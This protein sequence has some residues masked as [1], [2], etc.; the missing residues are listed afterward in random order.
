MVDLCSAFFSIP[1]AEESRHLFAFTYRG[2]QYSYK[3]TPQGFCH[4][5]H[6]FNQALKRDLEGLMLNSTLI[7]YVDDLLVCAPTLEDCHR[8]S[9]KLL[10]TL[11]EG[12]HKA[13]KTKLQYCQPQV[14]YLGRVISQGTVSI[15]PAQLEGV[16]KAPK[17]QTDKVRNWFNLN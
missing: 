4:S 5:P 15:A 11:A 2:E 10:Q 17:P 13:S 3:R 14:E 6:I 7:Q 12:G 9:V 1:L 8:D 16:S